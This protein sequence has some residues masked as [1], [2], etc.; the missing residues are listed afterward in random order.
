MLKMKKGYR[1]VIAAV[2]T[3]IS[4]VL[5]QTIGYNWI[6]VIVMITA[7]VFSG[8]PIFWKA[9]SQ[10]RFRIIGIDALVTIAVTGALI[11]GE[12]WEAAAVT[13]LFIFGDYL[14]SK[15]IEKTRSSIRELLNLAPEKARVIRNGEEIIIDPDEVG[16]NETVLIKPGEK[17]SVD[18]IVLEG[19]AFVN[20]SAIT[21]ESIP[22]EK[23]KD[24]RVYSGT[25][26][27][28][29][30]LKIRAEKVGKSTAFS[31]IMKMVEEAQ[32]KKAKT[33]KFI[34]KFSRY[35]TPVVV[36]IAILVFFIKQD[37]AL[38]LTFLVISCPG[39]LVISTPVSLVAGIGN[40]AKKGILFKGGEVIETLARAKAFAF[41]K[42]GTLTMGKPEV[43]TVKTYGISEG[44]LLSIAANGESYSEHPLAGAII[45][46]AE[47]SG[48]RKE[49]ITR[50]QMLPG[51]GI[52][53][54]YQNQSYQIGNRVLFSE[55]N[56][57]LFD[58]SNDLKSE[59][60]KGNTVVLVGD[61]SRVLGMISVADKLRKESADLIVNLKKQ[62]AKHTVMISGDNTR[63]ARAIASELGIS[64]VYG[65]L[66]PEDKVRAVSEL[67]TKYGITAMVGDGINDTPALAA[68][69][70]GIAV[71]GAGKDAAMETADVVLLSD[72]IGKLSEAVAVSRATVRNMTQNIAFALLVA[73]T[74][75]AGVLIETVSLS[76][77]MLIHELSV[78]LVIINAVRL[79]GF[80]SRIEKKGERK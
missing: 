79:L 78:L 55:S 49:A 14:E 43:K 67:K 39:A 7:T 34:E 66:L 13:F 69:D 46:K 70:L 65:D 42:T 53:F 72:K 50:L 60:E 41:D 29:G 62:G 18:G 54:T 38:S 27:E 9:I 37:I 17:I 5:Y 75:L 36:L 73:A 57:P 59:E 44:N 26:V 15:T 71:G 63:T 4:F 20:Q 16:V 1:I 40:A 28:S 25:V 32:D 68:A 2:L 8:L 58:I 56:I 64:E 19:N 3:A 47:E 21:G 24:D 76:F 6:T 61:S 30:Y 22:A 23:T 11:I 10:F 45:E 31:K 35:Y 77:G 74:L 52:R 80:K 48:Y 51:K 12:Y 33:Q